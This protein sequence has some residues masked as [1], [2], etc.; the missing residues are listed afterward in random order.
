MPIATVPAIE[1]AAANAREPEASDGV[2]P[3]AIA[4]VV[5][6]S[7][8][9]PEMAVPPERLKTELCSDTPLVHDAVKMGRGLADVI[10]HVVD[11]PS[12]P[13]RASPTEPHTLLFQD[14]LIRPRAS[15]AS[16]GQALS[17]DNADPIMHNAHGKMA[18]KTVVNTG[19][20]RGAPAIRASVDHGGL[21]QIRCD[22]HLW[23]RA[24]VLFTSHGRAA[25]TKDDGRF[26][27][28]SLARGR[29]AIE[30]WHAVFGVKRHD[31]DVGSGKSVEITF[32]AQ[33][34]AEQ[35]RDELRFFEPR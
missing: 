27:I 11:G 32:R 15:V 16:V 4:G 1:I 12:L 5:R 19:Q 21:L 35:A 29:Y 28:R 23:E 20:P 33:D 26:E 3:D 31:V 18:G 10:V 24:Y 8:R 22:V 6:V 13:S 9:A 17:I 2:P 7:G 34:R 25:V 30:A 14:C